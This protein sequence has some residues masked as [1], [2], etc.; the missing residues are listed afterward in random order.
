[1][2]APLRQKK[3]CRLQ[4]RHR[5]ALP[6]R[7]LAG[8]THP[9]RRGLRVT[10]PLPK[11]PMTLCHC[12]VNEHHA[13]GRRLVPRQCT[14]VNVR[15]QVFHWGHVRSLHGNRIRTLEACARAIRRRIEAWRHSSPISPRMFRQRQSSSGMSGVRCA[16]MAVADPAEPDELA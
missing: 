7:Y 1:M 4:N 11:L 8:G 14:K 9:Q 16:E 3:E 10:L 13:G 2:S 12:G 15:P 5:L 6:R